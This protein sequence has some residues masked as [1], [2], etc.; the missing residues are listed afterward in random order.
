MIQIR[1]VW[2]D[3]LRS[4]GWW[5]I[6]FLLVAVDIINDVIAFII[7]LDFL[8]STHFSLFY[9]KY[10]VLLNIGL[11]FAIMFTAIP[12]LLPDSSVAQKSRVKNTV[13]TFILIA[14]FATVYTT[15]VNLSVSTSMFFQDSS[16]AISSKILAEMKV[17]EAGEKY[18]EMTIEEITDFLYN[19]DV[20]QKSNYALGKDVY[21]YDLPWLPAFTM[22]LA[23]VV[24]LTLLGFNAFRVVIDFAYI[25]GLSI[26]GL[27]FATA[28]EQFR[29]QFVL[30]IQKT[31]LTL[32][33]SIFAIQFFIVAG[34]YILSV[35]I[36]AEGS[37]LAKY[38]NDV[39][40]QAIVYTFY[41]ALAMS[42]IIVITL[43]GS[44]RTLGMFGV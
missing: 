10:S 3:I 14:L 38:S 27:P 36:F 40:K 22:G 5:I 17:R 2:L 9:A 13:S 41:Y 31:L 4:I 44:A 24:G 32:P 43:D 29:K 15:F 26:I 1:E 16:S 23:L 28:N 18:R 39:F 30:D 42:G 37:V 7:K 20:N 25:K 34:N 19:G 12:L 8:N 6:K 33:L 35:D 11:I 21:D